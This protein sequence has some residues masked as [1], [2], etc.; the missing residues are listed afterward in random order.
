MIKRF[1]RLH[2][3]MSCITKVSQINL[4]TE[5]SQPHEPSW[6]H[7]TVKSKLTLNLKPLEEIVQNLW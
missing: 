3:D 6:T 4:F 2:P 1:K 7:I 5:I